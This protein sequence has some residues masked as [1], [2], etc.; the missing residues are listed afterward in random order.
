MNKCKH[1]KGWNDYQGL[2]GYE[3]RV[4]R[5]CGIDIQEM[6]AKVPWE[7]Q[8]LAPE[9]WR[10]VRAL[11]NNISDNPDDYPDMSAFRQAQDLKERAMAVLSQVPIW[12]EIQIQ[13]EQP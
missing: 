4:C 9:L 12:A 6:I 3:S 5:R 1:D 11:K 2:L 8:V 10:T 7:L 13:G